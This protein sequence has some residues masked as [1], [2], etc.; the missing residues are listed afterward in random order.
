M[1]PL[2]N[3]LQ[4]GGSLH[5]RN[6]HILKDGRLECRLF[7][8]HLWTIHWHVESLNVRFKKEQGRFSIFRNTSLREKCVLPFTFWNR[9]PCFDLLHILLFLLPLVLL[10]LLA[11]RLRLLVALLTLGSRAALLTATATLWAAGCVWGWGW[12][13]KVHIHPILQR[14]CLIY[15]KVGLQ[16]TC[17]LLAFSDFFWINR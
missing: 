11:C 6:E 7:I 14:F 16:K 12:R 5:H 4:S 13:G 2:E 10:V 17:K 9:F 3:L 1:Q 8:M 15:L